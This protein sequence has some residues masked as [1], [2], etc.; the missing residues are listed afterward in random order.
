MK[1]TLKFLKD[2]PSPLHKKWFIAADSKSNSIEIEVDSDGQPLHSFWFG[3]LKDSP[4]YFKLTLAETKAKIE[5]PKT[6]SE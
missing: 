4:D 5:T 6:K 2:F 3:Q 1:A